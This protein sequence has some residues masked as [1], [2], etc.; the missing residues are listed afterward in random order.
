[1]A[2][3]F[4]Q[5]LGGNSGATA[6][7][8]YPV[9][10]SSPTVNGNLVVIVVASDATVATPAGF[11]LDKSQV[12]SNGHYQFSKV[13]SGGETGWTV[14]PNSP[15]AGCWYAAEISG[16]AASPLDQAASTGSGTGAATRSTGTTGTTT[17]AAELAVASWGAS[18]VGAADTW[19]AQTNGFAERISDQGTTTGGSNIGLAVAAAVLSATGTV[20]ST[21]TAD[22]GQAPKSTGMVVTYKVAAGSVVDAAAALQAT[23]GRVAVAAVDRPAAAGLVAAA[24]LTSALTVDRGLVAALTVAATLAASSEQPASIGVLTVSSTRAGGAT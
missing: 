17:Q 20:E 7:A 9:M 16:L 23:A 1:M 6:P 13:S 22:G 14:T 19:G 10:L 21:A 8:T 11:A 3:A 5:E 2:A 4:V 15:A 12:N 18:T 24:G